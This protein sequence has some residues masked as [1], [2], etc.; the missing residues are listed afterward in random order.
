MERDWLADISV[1]GR[2]EEN[3]LRQIYNRCFFPVLKMV[4][5]RG[6]NDADGEDVF[7]EA[8]VV[9][10]EKVKSGQF[11]LHSRLISYLLTVSSHIWSKKLRK[12]GKET[13][14][15]NWSEDIPALAE[16]D[17]F[18]E[19]WAEENSATFYRLM[20]QL[21]EDCR[22]VLMAAIWENQSMKTISQQMGYQNA[23]IARNKKCRCL[24]YLRKIFRKGE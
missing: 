11:E 10:Y 4:N 9:L 5:Q 16:V 8:L 2:R 20:D 14:P 21:N 23:Q 7:Q 13:F 22:A 3:A 1:G 24:G 17:S 6:G 19:I 12:L 18:S 15:V